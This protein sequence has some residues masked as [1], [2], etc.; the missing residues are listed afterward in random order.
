MQFPLHLFCYISMASGGRDQDPYQR[1]QPKVDRK[2]QPKGDGSTIDV[3]CHLL[4][5]MRTLAIPFSQCKWWPISHGKNFHTITVAAVAV[6][7]VAQCSYAVPVQKVD[8]CVH[9]YIFYIR[10]KKV[11]FFIASKLQYNFKSFLYSCLHT[12]TSHKLNYFFTKNMHIVLYSTMYIKIIFSKFI[13]LL[14]SF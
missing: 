5:A 3:T 9:K 13:R 4:Q 2:Q 7:A 1:L 12:R 11:L 10:P 6:A 14:N 8:K